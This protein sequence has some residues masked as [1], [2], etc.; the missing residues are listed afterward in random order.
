MNVDRIFMF[1]VHESHLSLSL[2]SALG[3]FLYFSSDG[4]D[5]EPDGVSLY[6]CVEKAIKCIE[7]PLC[8]TK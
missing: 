5:F 3:K 2:E 7:L 6:K 8:G 1:D 4:F